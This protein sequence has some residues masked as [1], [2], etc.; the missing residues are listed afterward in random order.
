ML[1]MMVFFGSGAIT[2]LLAEKLSGK[3]RRTGI[4]LLQNGLR[5]RYAISFW[6]L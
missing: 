6:R 1:L 2:L 5:M 3:K 4:G